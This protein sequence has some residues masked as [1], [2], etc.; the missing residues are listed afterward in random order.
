MATIVLFVH[1]ASAHPGSSD[2]PGVAAGL[3]MKD[4]NK[5]VVALMVMLALAVA[6]LVI[7]RISVTLP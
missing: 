5:V 6:V 4:R 1:T 7:Y 2:D 3:R